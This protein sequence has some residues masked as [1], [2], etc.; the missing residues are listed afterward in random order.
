M[1]ASES[2]MLSEQEIGHVQ[3]AV[4]AWHR[5][6]QRMF[7]WRQTTDPYAILISEKLLQQTSA[8]AHVVHAFQILMNTFP[9][10]IALAQ[11]RGEELEAIIAPLGF[12]YRAKE[13]KVIGQYLVKRFHGQVPQ[14]LADLL[15]I[16][17][18]GDYAARA[19]QSFAFGMDV[20]IVDTNIAR[21][22]YRLF[23][24]QQTLPSNPSRKK[25][26]IYLAS[27]LIPNGKSRCFNFALLDLCAQVCTPTK[28]NCSDCPLVSV[29][30]YGAK[31]DSGEFPP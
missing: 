8:R 11:A 14:D 20:P 7:P 4:L 23:D 27:L 17:G 10:P 22:L 30:P 25:S 24:I 2:A 15:S 9:S 31:S 12:H 29:C 5:T 19:I 26:L 3:D 21:L 16:P 13:L 6:N 28:P 1:D 18:I